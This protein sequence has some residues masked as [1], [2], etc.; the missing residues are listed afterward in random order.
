MIVI[1]LMLL[2]FFAV[3]V[4]VIAFRHAIEREEKKMLD[5]FRKPF[6]GEEAVRTSK[7]KK[8]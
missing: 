1:F 7:K 5:M 6:P 3:A 2:A 8:R 4:T